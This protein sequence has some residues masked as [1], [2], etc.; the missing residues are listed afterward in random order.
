MAPGVPNIV[1]AR[2][3]GE[4]VVGREDAWSL[5]MAVGYV[6]LHL[7]H[8]DGDDG[9]VLAVP[10]DIAPDAPFAHARQEANWFASAL[11]MPEPTFT[12]VWREAGG[13][14]A[15][16]GRVTETLGLPRMMVAAR[17]RRLGLA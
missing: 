13:S 4:F 2:I 3:T 14:T 7:P 10:A 17:A 1:A 6:K 11:L 12:A 16:I 5:A 9:T 15:G 8:L